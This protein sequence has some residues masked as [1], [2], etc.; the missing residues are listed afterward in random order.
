MHV[1][2]LTL[3]SC[4]SKARRKGEKKCVAGE[5][6][7]GGAFRGRG[8]KKEKEKKSL[9]NKLDKREKRRTGDERRDI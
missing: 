8:E 6:R 7:R 3:L 9:G 4:Y 1:R 5:V 2:F